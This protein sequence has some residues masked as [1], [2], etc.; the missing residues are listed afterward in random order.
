MTQWLD[1]V[2]VEVFSNLNDSMPSMK[3]KGNM[4]NTGGVLQM[5]VGCPHGGDQGTKMLGMGAVSSHPS[6]S[7]EH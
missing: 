1:L 2:I 3:G 7:Q 6:L 4:E 5:P